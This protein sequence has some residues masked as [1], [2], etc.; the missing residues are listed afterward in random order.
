MSSPTPGSPNLITNNF[1]PPVLAFIQDYT[2]NE[3]TALTVQ[4]TAADADG[5]AQS[6]RYSLAPAVPDGAGI[7]P[8]TGVFTWSPTESQDGIHIVTISVRDG[9]DPTL[10][11]S[12]SFRVTVNEVNTAPAIGPIS[13]LTIDPGVPRSLLIPA[14]DPDFPAQALRYSML[15]GPPG[16]EVDSDGVFNWTALPAQAGSTNLV[17]VTVSD[18]GMPSLSAAR[19]FFVYVNATSG[20]QGIKGDVVPRLG[21]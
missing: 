19:S 8:L 18:G 7:D 14:T 20:C 1:S 3:G 12:R 16:A 10:S 5:S 13:N 11:D 15:A 6:L 17:I 21:G 9:G 2:I 4:C